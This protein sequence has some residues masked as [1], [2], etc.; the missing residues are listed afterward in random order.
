MSLNEVTERVHKLEYMIDQLYRML[1][2]PNYYDINKV[3][4]AYQTR[5]IADRR[6]TQV[7]L[8]STNVE[9]EGLIDLGFHE[10]ETRLLEEVRKLI[11]SNIKQA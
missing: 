5:V 11:R 3:H 4:S 9:E 1:L 10:R 2:A 6:R 7:N 8:N